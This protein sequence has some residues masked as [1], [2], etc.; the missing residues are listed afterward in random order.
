MHL[1][2][3][4]NNKENRLI[5]LFFFYKMS[6]PLR[7]ETVEKYMMDQKWMNYFDFKE[8]VIDLQLEGYIEE[9]ENDLRITSK[10]IFILDNFKQDIPFSIRQLIDNYAQDNR[11]AIKRDMQVYA[12]YSQ[13]SSSEYPVVLRLSENNNEVL[14]LRLMTST[15]KEAQILC[16]V[17]KEN[18]YDIYA[19]V[20]HRIL[21]KLK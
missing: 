18:A 6:M 9:Y 4:N 20:I 7:E 3:I 13:D 17:F 8:H 21:K 11:F 14:T 2:D 12:D 19:D 1:H 10:G 5:I 16:D 15:G